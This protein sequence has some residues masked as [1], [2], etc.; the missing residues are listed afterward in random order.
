MNYSDREIQQAMRLAASEGNHAAVAELRGML[1]QVYQQEN[2]GAATS[3]MSTGQKMAAN[4]G[5]GM[6]KVGRGIGQSFGMADSEDVR[7]AMQRDEQLA[8][9]LPYAGRALQF[10]GEAAPIV[11]GTAA[12]GVASPALAA[13][14]ATLRG[15]AA[16]GGV[17]GALSQT[18]NENMALGKLQNAAFGAGAGYAGAKYLP[19]VADAVGRGVSSARDFAVKQGVGTAG[20]RQGLAERQLLADLGMSADDAAARIQSGLADEMP[21]VKPTTAQLTNSR[22]LLQ[23]ERA[24]R[25][26]GGEAGAALRDRLA[27]S[28]T[29]R[30]GA[31]R[32]ALDVDPERIGDAASKFAEAAKARMSLKPGGI[33]PKGFLKGR[34]T[35]WANK[36]ENPATKAQVLSLRDR[37]T[38]IQGAPEAKQLELIHQFRRTALND[39]L[40]A[41]YRTDK[42]A[43]KLLRI[44][45]KGIE[46]SL[47]DYMESRLASG[48]W[49]GFMRGYSSRMKIKGQAEAGKDLLGRIENRV[50]LSTGE[51]GLQSSRQTIRSALSPENATNRYGT[52]TFGT[53]ARGTLEDTLRSLDVE[54][55]AFAPDVRPAGSATAENLQ[56]M[57]KLG[58]QQNFTPAEWLGAL[59]VGASTGNPVAGAAVMGQRVLAHKAQQDIAQRL[60]SL[61]VDPEAALK[62]LQQTALS[63]AEKSA[64]A[65]T[66]SELAG[67]ASRS[68]LPL[69]G[70][71]LGN[72]LLTSQ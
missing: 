3:G 58:H 68:A 33:D 23:T 37:L 4:L 8:Q 12:A 22:T 2:E 70:T 18:D 63:E 31:V 40:D 17:V 42:Q 25:E 46:K 48:S 56:M 69:A 5:A 41:A 26:T 14:M 13:Y 43:A 24:L 62:V 15:A 39:T 36:I 72:T 50:P 61:Y 47:D 67:Y 30:M 34:V 1:E 71:A 7:E 28:N 9:S 53:E 59:G 45:I 19:K 64:V 32:N 66:I 21:G 52:Q 65:Q 29:A 54:A 60:L 20:A 51:P 44:P 35:A 55:R 57:S 49:K 27:Q 10:L 16:T 6:M 38:E 11:A